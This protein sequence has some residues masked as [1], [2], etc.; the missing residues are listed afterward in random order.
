ML[1]FVSPAAARRVSFH[2]Q[3]YIHR[4]I[5]IYSFPRALTDIVP[6]KESVQWRLPVEWGC[7]PSRAFT[8]SYIYAHS[9]LCARNAQVI[10]RSRKVDT[11]AYKSELSQFLKVRHSSF[12]RWH[13]RER[14]EWSLPKGRI[15]DVSSPT[16]SSPAAHRKLSHRL[17]FAARVY[18]VRARRSPL[19]RP[20]S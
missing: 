11:R 7:S 17:S 19:P 14:D 15:E 10:I 13:L 2:F 3:S 16:V 20:E 4:S 6:R 1:S 18:I 12:H 5:Y 8:E 9:P